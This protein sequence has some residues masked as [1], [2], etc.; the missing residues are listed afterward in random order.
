MLTPPYGTDFVL[1]HT[2]TDS[3]GDAVSGATVT[4]TITDSQVT[5]WLNGDTPPS[6]SVLLEDQAMN[7]ES[8]GTYTYTVADTLLTVPGAS[9]YAHIV[10][11]SG[12]LQQYTR[13]R[14]EPTIDE[15]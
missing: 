9:Y 13:V 4:V 1:T 5:D 11:I 2:L 8:D 3:A 6:G 10:A 14:I 12:G 15:A 7:D